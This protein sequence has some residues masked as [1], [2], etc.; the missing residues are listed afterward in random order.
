[1]RNEG[2]GKYREERVS[3]SFILQCCLSHISGAGINSKEGRQDTLKLHK[4]EYKQNNIYDNSR[5]L[6][7]QTK[8]CSWFVMH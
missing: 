6:Q 1:V 7:T 4:N 8:L 2:S 3:V 5:N